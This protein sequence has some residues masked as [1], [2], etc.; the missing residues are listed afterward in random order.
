MAEQK[1]ASQSVE[2]IA[3]MAED[4]S[5][6]ADQN[7]ALSTNLQRSAVELDRLVSQFKLE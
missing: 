7:A 4:N 1:I 2:Q 5:A 6:R 3:R